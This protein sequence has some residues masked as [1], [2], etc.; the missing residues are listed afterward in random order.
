MNLSSLSLNPKLISLSVAMA[1]SHTALAQSDET[2]PENRDVETIE[3]TATKMKGLPQNTPV[4]LSVI[5]GDDLME[6][7]VHSVSDLQNVAPSVSIGRSSF[8]VNLNIRGVTTTDVT[9]KGEQ[10][11]A[12]IVDGVPIGR[13]REQGT[14]FFDISRVEILRG[15]QGTLYG[16]SSTGG[17]INVVTNRPEFDFGASLNAE[18][19]NYDSQK[20]TAV[21]NVP[22]TEKFALRG[23]VNVNKRDGYLETADGSPARN[24]RDDS[25]YRLSGLYEFDDV[26]SLFVSSSYG[27]IG[28]VG[29][30]FVNIDTVQNESGK[31]Q[32]QIYGNPID[33]G[34]D[35][36]FSNITVNFQTEFNDIALNYIAGYRDYNAD[37]V[38]S[39]TYDY[40][41]AADG[42]LDWGQY[43]GTA[44]T[45]N[46]E[47]TLSAADPGD[48]NWVV[49]ANYFHED[50]NESDHYWSAP[51]DDA[52]LAT[53]FNAVN[54][55]NNTTHES[56][57]LFGQVNYSVTDDLTV[58]VGAR[59]S[60]DAVD[61]VGT[62]APGP[63]P[64]LNAAGETCSA[65]DDCIGFPNVASQKD[66]KITWRLGADYHTD[67]GMFFASVATGYKAGGFND[68]DPF[69]GAAA[70][71]QS[72]DPESLTAYEIGYKG[73]LSE[74]VRLNSSIYYYDYSKTQISY[75]VSIEGATVLFTRSEPTTIM[76]WE[77]EL[78][79]D[80]SDNDA[81]DFAFT[82]A[83]SE[84]KSFQAGSALDNDWSGRALDK[85]ADA[86]AMVQYSHVWELSDGGILRAQLNSR[87][88]SGYVVSYFPAAAQFDQDAFTR[89]D[90]TLTYEDTDGRFTVSAFV[91]NLE[92]EVQIISAPGEHSASNP[93][94]TTVAVSEPR[95]FGVR[96]GLTY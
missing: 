37:T 91:T 56:K 36:E 13:P 73:K 89:T 10:G 43:R 51:V 77:N 62:F 70:G 96:V 16:K 27:K 93:T 2:Q 60:S 46:H 78:K 81:L 54:A 41:Q 68:F 86:T 52:S 6:K 71:P 58:T 31:A 49:G 11:I 63:G 53:S 34:V 17:V 59:Y 1:L 8:G 29:V 24:D 14:A 9:S 33:A 61:R 94:N 50:L 20:T 57:G 35:E 28:G 82:L 22:V 67:T 95:M 21:V 90:A 44:V 40:T 66:E 64:W 76:G 72:Y 48:W 30:G 87:Y 19:G 5:G 4:A 12:F 83:D 23:A 75:L 85:V 65:P 3:V 7:G 39:S 84:Y 88:N 74:N 15:P 92:D 42:T 79:W 32:R 80:I 47:I 55:V 38:S 45:N 25:T 26:T 69:L 18:F